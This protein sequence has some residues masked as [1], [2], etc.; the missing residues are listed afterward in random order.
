MTII[1]DGLLGT[2]HILAA[3]AWVGSVTYHFVAVRPALKVLGTEYALSTELRATGRYT[4][5]TWASLAVLAVSGLAIVAQR[6]AALTPILTRPAGVI[7]TVKLLLVAVLTGFFILQIYG[8]DPRARR[9]VQ[10]S[11]NRPDRSQLQETI[12][13]RNLLFALYLIVGIIVIALSVALSG[14]L[15]PVG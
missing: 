9:L 7:L 5:F 8:H 13:D 15:R 3:V 4:S 12:R 14:L 6:W 10:L 1:M 2:L 11:R